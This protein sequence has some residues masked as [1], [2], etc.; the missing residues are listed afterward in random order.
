M[1]T[2]ATDSR[3]GLWTVVTGAAAQATGL[4]VDAWHHLRAPEAAAHEALLSPSNVGHTLLFGG[5]A[6]VIVGAVLLVLGPRLSRAGR[7]LRIAT[8]VALVLLL[9]SA[10]L[11]AANTSLGEPRHVHDHGDAPA[12]TPVAVA[13]HQP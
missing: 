8:P 4:G 12:A 3:I 10:T 1:S 5:M 13:H 2:R 9:G 6:A 11:A 7:S